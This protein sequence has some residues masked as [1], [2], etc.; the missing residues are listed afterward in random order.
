[1]WVHDVDTLRILA[2][3]EAA[4]RQYGWTRSQLLSMTCCP[5]TIIRRSSR[6]CWPATP[7]VRVS[8]SPGA[9]TAP[10]TASS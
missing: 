5:R 4:V 9:T 2:V 6:N 8:A 10:G 3:N 7:P 1:M